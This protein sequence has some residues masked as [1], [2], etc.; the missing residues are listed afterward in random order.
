[1]ATPGATDCL[2][3]PVV[4]RHYRTEMGGKPNSRCRVG[5]WFWNFSLSLSFWTWNC[6][7]TLGRCLNCG[8]RPN[9]MLAGSVIRWQDWWEGKKGRVHML[10]WHSG[11]ALWP[12]AVISIFPGSTCAAVGWH[13]SAASRDSGVTHFSPPFRLF[14]LKGETVL[15]TFLS[16]APWCFRLQRYLVG[17]TLLGGCQ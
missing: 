15:A 4:D 11:A 2:G 17:Y 7:R 6:S 5:N 12:A 16:T 1:M 14:Y 13:W 3:W 10:H 9:D 8:G